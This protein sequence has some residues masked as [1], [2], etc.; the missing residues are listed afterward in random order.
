[1]TDPYEIAHLIDRFSMGDASAIEPLWHQME[2]RGLVSESA[3]QLIELCGANNDNFNYICG[4]IN[5]LRELHTQEAH[6]SAF[7]NLGLIPVSE[8]YSIFIAYASAYAVQEY[9]SNELQRLDSIPTP[10]GTHYSEGDDINWRAILHAATIIINTSLQSKQPSNLRGCTELRQYITD[11]YGIGPLSSYRSNN[12]LL[13][14]E[15]GR[16]YIA[17][18]YRIQ[19][20]IPKEERPFLRRAA[21][22]ICET[23]YALV[24]MLMDNSLSGETATFFDFG[25]VRIQDFDD[26]SLIPHQQIPLY[27]DQAFESYI[28][29]ISAFQAGPAG[30]LNY[31]EQDAFDI[32]WRRYLKE[33]LLKVEIA[34][35]S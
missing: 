33:C 10:E 6:P 19:N 18:I 3:L 21:K 11:R 7:Y 25:R 17:K 24:R 35:F 2:A 30:V 23:T 12:L 4:W 8:L 15:V 16:S 28:H 22:S 1:M 5:L 31:Q 26:A 9:Y 14:A 27:I 29:A 13:L 32:I 34:R 20:T